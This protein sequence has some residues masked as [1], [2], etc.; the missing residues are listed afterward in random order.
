MDIIHADSCSVWV[1]EFGERVLNNLKPCTCGARTRAFADAE[2]A[3]RYYRYTPPL[4]MSEHD[5]L[6]TLGIKPEL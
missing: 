5:F 4:G 1:W 6:K 3:R 2:W